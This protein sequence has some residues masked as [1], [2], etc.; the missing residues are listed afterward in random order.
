MKYSLD[1]NTCIRYLNGR[2]VNIGRKLPTI[3]A[4]EIIV[5]SV[6]RGELAYGAAKSQTPVQSAAK[7]QRF[8]KP[9]ATLPYDD[10]AA[11]EFGRIRATLE[12]AGTPIGPYDM[13]I[14]A[15][16]LVHGLIVVTGNTA[17]FGRIAGLQIENWEITD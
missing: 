10:L 15:I 12:T 3:P 16:A 7:Q 13:Q 9:Y 6:V 8:L 1:T 4:H 2:S 14:A 11:V 17:E 5:C